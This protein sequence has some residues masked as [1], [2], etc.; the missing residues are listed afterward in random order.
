MSWRICKRLALLASVLMLVAC[1]HHLEPDVEA[2]TPDEQGRQ[3]QRFAASSDPF[4]A[5]SAPLNA[6]EQDRVLQFASLVQQELARAPDNEVALIGRSGLDLERFE[7]RYSHGGIL[8]KSGT[9]V[10]WSVRQLYYDCDQGKPRLFDQGLAGYLLSAEAPERAFVSVVFLPAEAGQSLRDTALDKDLV[11]Q[12]LAGEYSANAYPWSTRYQNCNQWTVEVLASAWGD[13]QNGP[14]LRAHAQDWL[15]A[16]EYAPQ[17]IHVGSYF[18][19]WVASMTPLIHLD[20]RPPELRQG[21]EFPVSLPE[22]I[23]DFARAQVPQARRIEFCHDQGKMV[24][25]Y[26]WQP[27]G[28]TCE[29]GPQDR[30]L[31]LGA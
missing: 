25:R 9:D 18:V 23:E 6:R 11:L 29:A 5:T 31:S 16:Q 12:L 2:P 14:D 3:T 26:G 4:C 8:L 17:K 15:R 28:A 7:L 30:V 20:D 21:L 27:L 24:I 1:A 19:K 13:L 10:P 22:G